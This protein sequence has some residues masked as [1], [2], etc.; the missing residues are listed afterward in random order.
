VL[1]CRDLCPGRGTSFLLPVASFAC[2][3]ACRAGGRIGR[4]QASVDHGEPPKDYWCP[5][6]VGADA[7]PALRVVGARRG[8]ELQ[9]HLQ[10][11]RLH[12]RYRQPVHQ[13]QA[14]A[15]HLH[16]AALRRD[17]LRHPDMP[18]LRRPRRRRLP[19]YASRSIRAFGITVEST[20]YVK[21]FQIQCII[22][23][24]LPHYTQ[25]TSSDWRSSH[26]PSRAARTSSRART[27]R[28]RAR[29]PWTRPSSGRWGSPT[30]SGTTG[31]SAFS[32]SGSSRSPLPSAGKVSGRRRLS[33]HQHPL[34]YLVK[35]LSTSTQ[36]AG[37]NSSSSCVYG[38]AAKATW[39]TPYSC[40]ANSAATTTT[41]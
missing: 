3:S 34:H 10:L 2:H 36:F 27:W 26:R 20:P 14:V 30:R 17:L 38:Q 21:S 19:E 12:H 28:S 8:A 32:S 15:D 24:P 37:P 35:I 33:A 18:L 23:G 16:P 6:G 39:P 4:H 40:S 5:A 1:S 9:C 13:R 29:R 31:P 7:D 11:R 41:P 25:P 22:D